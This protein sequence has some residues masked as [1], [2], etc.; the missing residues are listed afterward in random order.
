M[1][2]SLR[3]CLEAAP[4]LGQRTTLLGKGQPLDPPSAG[5]SEILTLK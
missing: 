2:A 3:A 4:P 5:A 1:S